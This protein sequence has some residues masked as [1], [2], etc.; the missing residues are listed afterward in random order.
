MAVIS[1]KKNLDLA[2][3][4][5]TGFFE[6]ADHDFAIRLSNFI[7]VNPIWRLKVRKNLKFC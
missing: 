4:W 2:K 3:N 6:V 7:M 1:S 5:Y